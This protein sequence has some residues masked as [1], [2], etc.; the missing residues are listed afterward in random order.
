[1]KDK[2]VSR[3]AFEIAKGASASD[4]GTVKP[5]SA[6]G[7]DRRSSQLPK[8]EE[9]ELTRTKSNDLKKL[10]MEVMGESNRTKSK[11]DLAE[12]NLQQMIEVLHA[13]LDNLKDAATMRI[14]LCNEDVNPYSTRTSRLAPKLGDDLDSGAITR[15][16]S[17]QLNSTIGQSKFNK[18]N[19]VS[20]DTV[21][22]D[23]YH[24][25][26]KTK[27]STETAKK[28][29]GK[30]DEAF[31]AANMLDWK[32][33]N[34]GSNAREKFKK[35][36]QMKNEIKKQ[37]KLKLE[38]R[39]QGNMEQF[40]TRSI[41]DHDLVFKAPTDDDSPQWPITIKWPSRDP[42]SL[43]PE[44]FEGQFNPELLLIYG[45]LR[46]NIPGSEGMFKW[47]M[48]QNMMQEYLIYLF[49][50]LKLKFF[51]SD[52]SARDEAYLLRGSS[53]QYAKIL[54]LIASRAYTEH[55]KDFSFKYLP[56]IFTNAIYFGFYFLCPGSRHIY[57]KSFKKTVYMQVVQI[58]HGIQLCPVSVKVTW[59]QL[60][61]EDTN[62]ATEEDEE[63]DTFPVPLA[64]H[65]NTRIATGDTINASMQLTNNL[66]SI[67]RAHTGVLTDD[68][69]TIVHENNEIKREISKTFEQP[70]LVPHGEHNY[71]ILSNMTLN[72]STGK[73]VMKKSAS[74]SGMT[75]VV[76]LSRTKLNPPL[77]KPDNVHR[78]IER[79]HIEKIDAKEMSPL[80]QQYLAT[81][82]AS[83][84]R[85]SQKLQRTV[86]ISWCI[87]GGS[88]TARKTFINNDLHN[89]ISNKYHESVKSFK[90]VSKMSNNVKVEL[91]KI[92]RAYMTLI[93]A[94]QSNISRFSGDLVRRERNARGELIKVKTV[95]NIFPPDPME[96]YNIQQAANDD[97][98]IELESFLHDLD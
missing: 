73:S 59:S 33:K 15:A 91:K 60:F 61:P 16:P 69:G 9:K 52:A 88:D 20:N 42:R 40:L 31:T 32:N 53:V 48:K 90:K 25:V 85:G 76:P 81:D 26:L 44:N 70:E 54:E 80:I 34:T 66:P 12:K 87:V 96:T 43:L 24:L 72:K 5:N 27:Q 29:E 97:D 50:L 63:A 82:Y 39:L 57:T 94:G 8:H 89:E 36:E 67:N 6:L 22:I 93:Q 35:S 78:P 65:N 62:D 86:P 95:N 18:D 49:W 47:L 1:M 51:Q 75:K 55:E 83:G 11:G 4:L 41:L 68:D 38:K 10:E 74:E 28:L 64:F 56:F 21:F 37:S 17:N 45:V 14:E 46:S 2:L 92:D 30:L 58:M 84:V 3:E 77:V 19:L 71:P 79:Q 13:K 23:S 98:L 7:T